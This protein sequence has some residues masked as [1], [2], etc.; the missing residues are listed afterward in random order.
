VLDLRLAIRVLRATPVVTIVAILSLA[1]GIGANTAIFSIVDSLLLRALPVDRPDRLA[2]LASNPP[3]VTAGFSSWSNPVWEQIRDRRHE[4]FETAFAFSARTTRFNLASS[5]QTEFIDGLWVS[6]DYFDGLGVQ[7]ISGRTFTTEDDRHGGGPNGP[8]AVISYGFWQRRFA[9]DADVIGRTQTIERVPFTIVGVMPAGFFGA[10]VGSTFDVA[11]PLGT[12]PLMR[13]RDSALDLPTTSWLVVMARLKDGQTLAS[14]QQGVRVVQPQ[15]RGATMPSDASADTKARYLAAPIAVL[16]AALGTSAMRARYREPLLAIMIVV[17]LVLLIACA[18]IANLLLTRAAARRHEFSVRFALGA[19]RWRLARQLVVES[20]LL[21]G[22]GGLIALAIA[23]WGSG[24]LVRQ[25]STHA[26]TVFLDVQLDWRVLAFTAGVTS[27]AALLFGI[28]PALRA[29]RAEPI[30]AIREHGRGAVGDRRV[31]FAAALVAG[32]VAMSLV[33]VATAGL[34]VRTFASLVTLDL[35]FDRDPVLIAQL[36]VRASGAEPAQRAAL[37]GRMAGVA[38]TLAGVSHASVSAITPVSGSLIDVVVEIENG[39]PLTLPQNV[40]YRNVITPDWFATY[41]TRMIAGRDFDP[42]DRLASPLVTIVNE[43]FARKFLQGGNAI[44]RR[45]RHGLPGRQG[46]WLEIVGIVAD[47]TYRSLRDPVP[48]TLYVA[49]SQQKEPPPSMSLSVRAASGAP[50]MLS[51]SLAEVIGRVDRNVAITFTPLKQQVDAALVQERILA[52]LSG[53]FG[54]LALLLAGLGLYGMTWYAVSRRRSEIGVR[55]ALGATPASVVRL[56]LSRVSILV[57]A[58]VLVGLG[59]CLWASK[60]VAPLLYAV[61]PRDF[62]TLALSA[63][64]LAAV[65]TLAAWIP[66]H[67]A[68]R[69]DPAEVLRNS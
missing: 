60:L 36:D 16:P 44:G 11:V 26:N 8:V 55:M 49:L 46:P 62:A 38:R 23:H 61:Q 18:N 66:A 14:A 59:V 54:A 69:I 10:N 3:G 67:R 58:G 6:G 15:I 5:G 28:V 9:G 12:E 25:L 64:V 19:S 13:G 20:L 68:S 22:V 48:P 37:Y 4:L 50:A 56:V 29:S 1:L 21:S 52:M 39:P 42:R 24:L 27:L 17:V 47:A 40:S 43:T 7:P 30:E 53:F 63:G 41:G 45:I 2:L 35:G 51:R 65:G 31:G 34:F 57:S 33:L 32:Q